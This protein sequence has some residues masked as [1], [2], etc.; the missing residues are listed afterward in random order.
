M[1]VFGALGTDVKLVGPPVPQGPEPEL[2]GTT[3]WAAARPTMFSWRTHACW[4]DMRQ[5]DGER[6]PGQYENFWPGMSR[7][8]LGTRME[9]TDF[10]L[11]APEH[12]D[13][14]RTTL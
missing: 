9:D 13:P 11:G 8:V 2:V 14:P 7:W 10:V 12:W 1:R 3:R 4:F 6:Q 5:P